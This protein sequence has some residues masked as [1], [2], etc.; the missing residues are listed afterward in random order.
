[1]AT[2]LTF[3][4]VQ[5][6]WAQVSI[7]KLQERNLISGYPEGDFRPEGTIT[8]AEFAAIL[9]KAFPNAQ[10]VRKPA[11][12]T[13][14]PNTYWAYK[15][16]QAASKN[17]FFA[18]YPD[19]TFKPNQTIPRVQALVILAN[20]LNYSAPSP[21]VEMLKQYFEDATQVPDYAINAV[22]SAIFGNLVVNYPNVKQLKPNQN[23]TRGE[24]TALIA[25]ALQIPEA[26]SPQYIA[27]LNYISP[28]AQSYWASNFSEGLAA[29]S[30]GTL[31]DAKFGYADTNGKVVI[32]PQF[33]AANEFSEG[34]A[35][36]RVGYKFGYIDNTGKMVIQP[37]YDIAKPFSEGIAL[38]EID[39]K[40]AYIDKTGKRISNE[41]YYNA[42]SFSEGFALVGVVAGGGKYGYIDKTGKLVIPNKF[43]QA[44]SFSD[45]LALVRIGET[46]GYIDKTGN[47]PIQPH[48]AGESFSEGLAPVKIGDKF[49]YIDKTGKVVIQPQFTVAWPFSEGLAAAG[50]YGSFGYIDKTGKMVIQPKYQL[51]E[52]F[53]EGLALVRIDRPEGIGYAYGYID[54]TGKYVIY[55]QFG[56]AASFSEGVARVAIGGK[57]RNEELVANGVFEGGT[58]VYLRNPLK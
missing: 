52:P 29:F 18:G 39:Y 26:V 40:D 48:S 31:N 35:A 49:G 1:M 36:V 54:K 2:A 51:V 23:A 6:H 15:A 3:S 9:L 16:I 4:D 20:G 45:G 43:D 30:T 24:V 19:G 11:N 37:Q 21:S 53:S 56:D 8:R 55:P 17:G 32:Q 58:W 27:R 28:P 5:N 7:V 57:W 41:P 22:S 13:D 33:T 38:V 46:W 34:L 47:F 14:V 12:F 10:P 42:E 25:Q 50:N 44:K